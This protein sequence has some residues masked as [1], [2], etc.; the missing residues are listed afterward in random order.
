MAVDA[1]AEI[2][3]AHPAQRDAVLG[4]FNHYMQ[5]PN[6]TAYY[7]NGLLIGRL[8][9]LDAKESIEDI[10]RLFSLNCVDISCAGDLEEVEILLGLRQQRSTPKPNYAQLHGLDFPVFD[11]SNDDAY[12]DA[13]DMPFAAW[14]PPYT[15]PAPKIGRNDPCPCGS[16]KKFKKCCGA[17]ASG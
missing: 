14:Q 13:Y 5:Q 1:L 2:A 4:I 17:A 7:L 12:G 11:D 8:L 3:L 6:E 16:G 10:R 9:G 15:R